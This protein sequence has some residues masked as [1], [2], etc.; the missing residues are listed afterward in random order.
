MATVNDY[1][2]SADT[3]LTSSNYTEA[4]ALVFSQL[5]YY[6]F[7]DYGY[8]SGD[9]ISISEYA[10]NLVNNPS[11][12][13]S[14]QEITFLKNI[15]S[16]E[17]YSEC[18]M[19]NFATQDTLPVNG[20]NLESQWA[21]ITVNINDG[22]DTSVVAMRG[23]DGTTLGWYEDFQLAYDT[24]GTNAQILSQEYMKTV[25]SANIYATGHSKGGNDVLSGYMMSEESIRDRISRID[26]FE[27]PG[28]NSEFS[29][30]YSEG[31]SE[32]EDK[33]ISYYPQDSIIGRLLVD[34]PG[35]TVFFESRRE[36]RRESFRN[37]PI[38]GEHDQFSFQLE[39][40][41]LKPYTEGASPISDFFNYTLD[42]T[43]ESLTIEEREHSINVLNKLGIFSLIAGD[44][45]SP[46]ADNEEQLR[47][48]LDMVDKYGIIPDWFKDTI[49]SN[50]VGIAN[51]YEAAVIFNSCSDE[52]KDA[53]LHMASTGIYNAGEYAVN[54]V[55]EWAD[56]KVQEIETAYSNAIEQIKAFRESVAQRIAEIRDGIVAKINEA[57]EKY[58]EFMEN[59]QQRTQD[60][61]NELAKTLGGYG[62]F[63]VNTDIL[64]MESEKLNNIARRLESISRE[65][66]SVKSSLNIY[67]FGFNAV[68]L[69]VLENKINSKKRN[70]DKLSKG[71]TKVASA[72]NEAEDNI[73]SNAAAVS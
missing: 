41:G 58:N 44:G 38:V 14:E 65:V 57:K 21:A 31:Y 17:R 26:N 66:A 73:I 13:W 46:Y 48:T 45:E 7:E 54:E 53:I 64:Q 6:R 67:S 28:V 37:I 59:V 22:T 50:T 12:S 68:V 11:Q 62:E 72:Y 70:C 1:F 8:A 56:Q 39:G 55:R 9:E 42:E 5:S 69:T 49:S 60:F 63:S 25:D 43:V 24:D 32:L 30:N 61:I 23:T 18:T 20:E 2:A 40:D 19:T 29:S 35:D 15:A 33:L 4:D 16:S 51:L 36:D 71:L 3:P 34:K 27:G 10:Q 47:E 52:E